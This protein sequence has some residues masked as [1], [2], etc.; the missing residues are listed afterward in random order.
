MKK[1]TALVLASLLMVSMLSVAFADTYGLAAI[2]TYGA[3]KN[4]EVKD[5]EKYE[6]AAPTDTVIC[7]VVID[8][9]GKIKSVLFDTV[10]VRTKFTVE[11]K[12]V[13]GDYTAPVPSKI[14]KGEAY[15]MR[16]ASPIG[17]EWFEQIAAFE[18]YCIG[19]T[20]AE[21]Q[22]MPTKAANESHPTV[23]DVADLATTVTID[24]GGYIEALVKAASMAK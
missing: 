16:K 20:V 19:K 14:D 3:V 23:P 15:G 22:A 12:L 21:I 4:A 8:D 7:S 6:G 9:E 2:T 5:N 18:A 1:I 11:G 24:V 17:K 13:E 10:Q